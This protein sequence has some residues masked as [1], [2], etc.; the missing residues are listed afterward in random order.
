MYRRKGGIGKGGKGEY[1]KEKKGE[2]R[3]IRAGGLRSMK[4][5]KGRYK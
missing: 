5:N 1:V 3:M 2:A 4:R